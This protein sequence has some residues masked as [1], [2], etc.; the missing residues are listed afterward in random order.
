MNDAGARADPVR[1]AAV[2]L[3][4]GGVVYD[5]RWDVAHDL[6]RQ[7]GLAP[8]SLFTT[9]YRSQAWS[10][11]ERGRG[12]REAWLAGAH[13][14]LE[15]LAGR[16]LPPLHEQWRESHRVIAATVGLVRRLKA[17]YRVSILSNADI[18]LRTRLTQRLKIIDLFDDVVCSAEVGCAKPEPE[19]F[20]LACARLGL[21]PA[22]CVF[23]DDH[24]PNVRGAEAA[25][26]RGV[27]YRVDRGDDLGALLAKAG[28]TPPA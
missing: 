11:V 9:L 19:I 15:A 6:E 20:A 2:V 25:G 1:P 8:N 26:L 24:E 27:V 4:F 23:V 14:A 12:D 28:V 5:M 22:A 13:R 16:P 18:T 7:H 17:A 21:P 3:D 10:E